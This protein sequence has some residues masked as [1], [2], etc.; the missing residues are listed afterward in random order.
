MWILLMFVACVYMAFI[1]IWNCVV[2]FDCCFARSFCSFWCFF[3]S[4]RGR[5]TICALVPGVQT[6]AL[7]ICQ[8]ARQPLR[9]V[10]DLREGAAVVAPNDH[11]AVG[12]GGGERVV[13]GGEGPLVGH[14]GHLWGRV[15]VMGRVGLRR[16][17]APARGGSRLAR[18]RVG[19]GKRGSCR[20]ESGG[21]QSL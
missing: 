21:C 12:H 17:R 19:T 5:H 14:P 8:V 13:G 7:P 1:A 4:S 3:F 11:V 6:C 10:G 18:Q 20:V 15:A 9:A 2:C 16:P